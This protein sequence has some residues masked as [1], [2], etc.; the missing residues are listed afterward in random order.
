MSSFLSRR[1]FLEI[2]TQ[3]AFGHQDIATIAGAQLAKVGVKSKVTVMEAGVYANAKQETKL[4]PAFTSTWASFGDAQPEPGVVH[5]G[6]HHRQ[7]PPT[8]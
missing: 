7:V 6:K 4:G 8:P 2:Q 1:T 3:P 5:F